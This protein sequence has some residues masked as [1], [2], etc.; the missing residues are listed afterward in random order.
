MHS[1]RIY[2]HIHTCNKLEVLP[3]TNVYDID[4]NKALGSRSSGD[5]CDLYEYFCAF[6]I[7]V[8]SF[9]RFIVYNVNYKSMSPF[10]PSRNLDE[11]YTYN[12]I[13]L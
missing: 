7:L 5:T 1:I 4:V 9:H 3:F 10:I 13:W 8:E 12:H 2:I 6:F 11:V